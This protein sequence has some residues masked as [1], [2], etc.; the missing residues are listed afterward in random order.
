[1]T[2]LNALFVFTKLLFK[3]L[4]GPIER[5]LEA[6]RL[7]VGD[8]I[9]FMLGGNINVDLGRLFVAQIDDHLDGHQS[10]KKPSE[11]LGLGFEFLLASFAQMSVTD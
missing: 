5:C 3:L 9:V 11:L 10:F 4:N 8:K 2:F 7:H 6:F 1:M